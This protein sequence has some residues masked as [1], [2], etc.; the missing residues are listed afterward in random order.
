MKLLKKKENNMYLVQ[1]YWYN[2]DSWTQGDYNKNEEINLST[3]ELAREFVKQYFEKNKD[4]HKI[5]LSGYGSIFGYISESIE[6]KELK[7]IE[8]I[9]DYLHNENIDLDDNDLNDEI[10]L[11]EGAKKWNIN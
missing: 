5:Y 11:L 2:E 6:L 7:S 10:I 1:M 8:E 3:L 9:E 4:F